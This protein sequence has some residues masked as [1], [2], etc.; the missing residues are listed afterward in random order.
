MRPK[1]IAWFF[2]LLAFITC[3]TLGTWQVNRLAWKQG[4]IVAIADA[5]SKAPLTTLP[6]DAAALDALQF[7]KVTLK[8]TWRG[9]IEFH[10]APRYW[11]DKFGYALITPFTLVDGRTLLVNRGWIPA[12]KK[13]LADRPDT[14]VKGKA[15]ISGLIRVGNERTYFSPINQ[16][17]KNIWF[18]RDTEQMAAHANLKNPVPAMLDIVGTQNAK[19]LPVPSDGTIR[20]KND[21]LSYIIT[22]FGIALGILVIFVV[23]HRRKPA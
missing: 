4:L 12:K 21:H 2:F 9:D 3:L 5:N 20:L 16:P 15:T 19:T 22:W 23:Y 18:G 13:E 7:H 14:T 8:G 11:R 10:L 1:P 17:D 6:A